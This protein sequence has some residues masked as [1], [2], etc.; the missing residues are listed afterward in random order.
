M[1]DFNLEKKRNVVET[2]LVLLLLLIMLYATYSTLSA[3]FGIFT[4]AI[5][6]S[7]SFFSLFE[8]MCGW[9]GGKRKI[10]AFVYGLLLVAIVAVPFTYFIS[11]LVEY[12]HKAQGLI[13]DIK[14]NQVPA[15]PE[16]IGGI[17]YIG[18]KATS[19]WSALEKDPVS[20]ISA[21]E[22]Q[23]KS[24]LQHIL[25]AGGGIVST[26]LELVV[27]IIISAIFLAQGE[28]TLQPFDIFFKRLLGETN[29]DAVINASGRAIKG[30]AIG[31]MGT[32]LIEALLAWVGYSIAGIDMAIGLAAITFF[33]AVIQL[34]PLLVLIPVIIWLSS[35]GQTG[36]AIF[37]AVYGLVVLVGVD[38]ILKPILIGKSGKLPILVLFLGVIGGMGAWGFTGMFKGAIILAVAYTIFQSWSK[39]AVQNGGDT[40]VT[41]DYIEE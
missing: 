14:N 34:G 1:A 18:N 17:P 22:T 19:F 12:A 27:A 41:T 3:F 35:Q 13:A 31:V 38:N 8:K 26:G 28:K 32:A 40:K 36:W 23:L 37:M 4:F 39:N 24:F 10:A 29:G 16:W 30:V 25:S 33:L 21:Y 20:T 7:V 5:I 11:A 9:F 15:L 2:A 6:F